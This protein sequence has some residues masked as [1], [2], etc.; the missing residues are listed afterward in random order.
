MAGLS[1]AFSLTIDTECGNGVRVSSHCSTMSVSFRHCS[2]VACIVRTGTTNDH[3]TFTLRLPHTTLWPGVNLSRS[4]AR[5]LD[6]SMRNELR[7]WASSGVA[8]PPSRPHI[9]VSHS[10]DDAV[11]EVYLVSDYLGNEASKMDGV[12]ASMPRPISVFIACNS[13]RFE[14]DV[15]TM[16]SSYLGY[17]TTFSPFF[18]EIDLC[19]S[20]LEIQIAAPV[21]CNWTKRRLLPAWLQSCYLLIRSVSVKLDRHSTS[22]CRATERSLHEYPSASHYLRMDSDATG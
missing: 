15:R 16:S 7:T 1:R 20:A 4:A 18:T 6:T 19:L 17:N 22:I 3:A 8:V 2:A 21:D 5:P 14:V 10:I 12:G 9:R 11:Y 13:R